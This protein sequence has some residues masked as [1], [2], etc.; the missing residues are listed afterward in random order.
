MKTSMAAVAFALF[1]IAGVARASDATATVAGQ[2]GTTQ[3]QQWNF[4]QTDAT[5]KTRAEVRQELVQ[6]EKAGQLA[7]LRNLYRGS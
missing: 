1:A 7:S 6:A 4:S 2:P 3:T 5:Q